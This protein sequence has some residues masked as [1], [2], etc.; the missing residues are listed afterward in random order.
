[1]SLRFLLKESVF[2]TNY[3]H[4]H[5]AADVF[6]HVIL[7]FTLAMDSF[8]SFD[9]CFCIIA[10][11]SISLIAT[12]TPCTVEMIARLLQ[13]VPMLWTGDRHEALKVFKV[14]FIII[15]FVVMSFMG[16][17]DELRISPSSSG[18]VHLLISALAT[19]KRLP[20]K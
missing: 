11:V 6:D 3:G 5:M 19:T 18:L 10:S 8:C 7:E 9:E 2:W 17:G 20:D 15:V 4:R 12:P 13:E 14:D 1:M 16:F